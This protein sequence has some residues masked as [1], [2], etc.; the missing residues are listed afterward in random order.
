MDVDYNDDDGFMEV[1]DDQCGWSDEDEDYMQF[2]DPKLENNDSN[3]APKLTGGFQFT[4]I[5]PSEVA[6]RRQ[7]MINEVKE[8][9]GLNEE[10]TQKLLIK[11]RFDKD[12][13][14]SKMLEGTLE[15][16]KTEEKENQFDPKLEEHLCLVCFCEHKKEDIIIAPCQHFLCKDCYYYYLSTAVKG[17]PSCI[18]TVCPLTNCNDLMSPN[19]FQKVLTPEEYK[20][21]EKFYLYYFVDCNKALK[22]CPAPDCDKA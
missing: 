10:N 7:E 9:L 12:S 4:I 3:F 18:R 19:M 13:T 22:W 11:Q 6:N 15:E 21:Y 2:K 14:L 8:I 20:A 16:S 1:D 5:T 17:G